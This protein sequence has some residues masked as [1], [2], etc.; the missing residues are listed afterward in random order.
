MKKLRIL[1]A[2]DHALVRHGIRLLLQR[3]REWR[4][5]GEAINGREALEKAKKQKP[6][7]AILDVAMPDLDGLAVARQLRQDSPK[8]CAII[9]TMHDSTTL[10]RRALEAGARGYVL[11]SDL[12]DQLVKAVKNVSEEK[13][14]LTPKVS[15]IVLNGFIA[16]ED[17]S[18]LAARS[19]PQPTP[20]ELEIV[21]LLGEGRTNKEI[22]VQLRI[23]VRTVETHRAKVMLKLGVHSITQLINYAIRHR[24]IPAPID[25]TGE[26]L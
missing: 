26:V 24:I 19:E 25:S 8:T 13:L 15:E 10:V 20:R 22:A 14:F 9:L 12:A 23:T 1:I 17:K 11:K 2:D 16:P 18:N 3:C 6:D 5:V 4:V 21:R 7:I